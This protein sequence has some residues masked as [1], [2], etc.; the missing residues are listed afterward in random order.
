MDLLD[1][2]GVIL[3]HGLFEIVP[4]GVSGTKLLNLA[5]GFV[6]A[7]FE[8]NV[9]VLSLHSHVLELGSNVVCDIKA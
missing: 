3:G 1:L 5:S 8:D 6:L 2:P 9:S 4:V 7:D